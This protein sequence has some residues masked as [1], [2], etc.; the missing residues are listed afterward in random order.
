MDI[1]TE[2]TSTVIDRRRLVMLNRL[3]EQ[4]AGAEREEDVV[5]RALPLLRGNPAGATTLLQRARR[6]L[7]LYPDPPYGIDTAGLVQWCDDLLASLSASTSAD[8]VTVPTLRQ[9]QET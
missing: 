7:A 1:A 4:L 5:A 3:R 8:D 6:R 9:S 2:T